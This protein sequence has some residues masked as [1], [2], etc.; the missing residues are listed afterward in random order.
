MMN[1][2]FLDVDGVLNYSTMKKD[3][4]PDGSA[5]FRDRVAWICSD[6]TKLLNQV[7]AHFVLSSSWRYM[8]EV[9]VMQRML[10]YRGF[11][12]RLVGRTP[13]AGEL[14]N[15]ERIVTPVPRGHEIAEY[16]DANPAD[17]FAILDDNADM[18]HLKHRLVQTDPSEGLTQADVD[19]VKEMLNGD[20]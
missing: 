5:W 11:T 4:P 19:R 9:E 18:A 1:L 15:K 16:L 12:G 13:K 14:K 8:V 6:R 20:A 3:R 10:S 7:H 17:R 2:V